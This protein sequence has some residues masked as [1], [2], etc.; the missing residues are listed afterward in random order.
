M[1]DGI[2]GIDGLDSILSGR[3]VLTFIPPLS[4]PKPRHEPLE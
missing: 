4:S 3:A 2:D 1:M